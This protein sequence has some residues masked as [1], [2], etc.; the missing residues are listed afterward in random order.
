MRL[1]CELLQFVYV[2]KILFL[3]HNI[4]LVVVSS[5][6]VTPFKIGCTIKW[7]LGR[8]TFW[9]QLSLDVKVYGFFAC[10][11]RSKRWIFWFNVVTMVT[12]W[13]YLAS[14]LIS[15]LKN[16]THN[17]LIHAKTSLYN[18]QNLKNVAKLPH[19]TVLLN[20]SS[21]IFSGLATF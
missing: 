20:S 6:Y 12:R 9:Q 5:I 7:S 8:A 3:H 16:K 1:M 21:C 14:N 13:T 19:P 11:H 10:H 18:M 15:F 17:V 2:L 4:P